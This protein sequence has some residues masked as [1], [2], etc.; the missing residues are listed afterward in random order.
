MNTFAWITVLVAISFAIWLL[1]LFLN[2]ENYPKL[3]SKSDLLDL[4]TLKVLGSKLNSRSLVHYIIDDILNED[5]NTDRVQLVAVDS[6]F[7]TKKINWRH[8]HPLLVIPPAEVPKWRSEG[9]KYLASIRTR[10]TL[11]NSFIMVKVS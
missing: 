2:T 1:Y 6:E 8:A 4:F 7:V 9:Y 10:V 11:A 3:R 5:E